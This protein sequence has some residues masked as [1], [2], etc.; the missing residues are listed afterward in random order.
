[1]VKKSNMLLTCAMAGTLLT[2]SAFA[3]AENFVLAL[4][5]V[6]SILLTG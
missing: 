3:Y 4:R 5:H 1:M 6:P 2:S